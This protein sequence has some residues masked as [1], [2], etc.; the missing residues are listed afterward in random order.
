MN[1]S[2][3]IKVG[4]VVRHIATGQAAK[5]IATYQRPAGP[6]FQLDFGHSVKGPFGIEYNCKEFV[7][8]AIEPLYEPAQIGEPAKPYCGRI[9]IFAGDFLTKFHYI[10]A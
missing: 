9:P 6:T 5:V 8:Q 4:D 1:T 7:V 2:N 10:M 3:N